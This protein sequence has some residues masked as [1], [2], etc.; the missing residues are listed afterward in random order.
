M[1]TPSQLLRDEHLKFQPYVEQ[2]RAVAD[3]V[4]DTSIDVLRVEVD[5]LQHFL[6]HILLPHAHAED[7]EFYPLIERLLAAPGASGTMRRDHIEVARLTHELASARQQIT[8]TVLG[9]AEQKALRRILYGLYAI[10]KLHFAKE[11]EVYFPL[12]DAKMT[13]Q[14]VQ[15][16]VELMDTTAKEI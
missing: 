7:R 9:N 13:V 4:G 1:T 2:L 14:E 5:K 12:L 6:A 8:G 10:V 11:D 3:S 15:A 16:L